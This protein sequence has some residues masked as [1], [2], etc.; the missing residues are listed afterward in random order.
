MELLILTKE[1]QAVGQFDGGK[2]QERKPIGFPQDRGKLRPYGNLFYWA[3]ACANDDSLIGEHPHQGFEIMSFVLS[4]EIEH[5]DSQLRGWKKLRAGDVQIIRAG[6]GIT[7]AERIASGGSIFQIW[8]DPGLERTLSKQASY[9]DY[10][11]STFPITKADKY[12]SLEYV[13]PSN[14]IQMD[15]LPLSISKVTFDI[16]E[17]KLK[18]N[19]N[20]YL[21]SFILDGS[22]RISDRILGK[23]DFF[24]LSD[25]GEQSIVT[26][27]VTMFLI[28]NTIALDYKNYY[29]IVASRQ[30]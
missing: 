13:G 17:H 25:A 12:S 2:I 16:G 29:E 30:R 6:S 28:E 15:S 23:G 27:G 8:F 4:G 9:N 7:H 26:E 14:L 20:C 1:E 3:H 5:Y 24:R 18:V 10:E 11:A 22:I 21:S 19:A